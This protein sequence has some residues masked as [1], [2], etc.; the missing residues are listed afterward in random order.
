MT[1]LF[2]RPLDQNARGSYKERSRIFKVIG[3]L[4]NA[5][6]SQSISEVASSFEELEALLLPRLRT[7]DGTDVSAILN[8]MSAAEFDALLGGLTGV[9]DTVPLANTAT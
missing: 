2:V 5:Q 1:K 7:D 8:D 4:Q 3:R 6:Q 9:A